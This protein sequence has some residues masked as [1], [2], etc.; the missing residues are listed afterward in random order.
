MMLLYISF[1]NHCCLI[2]DNLSFVMHPMRS[3]LSHSQLVSTVKAY[4][5][6]LGKLDHRG[7]LSCNDL[8]CCKG[9]YVQ[10]VVIL[11]SLLI[12]LSGRGVLGLKKHVICFYLVN[13]QVRK[14]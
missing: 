14:C 1:S 7:T 13:Y 5:D 11:M 9:E 6:Q 4:A 8:F 12:M 10:E 3:V 2:C